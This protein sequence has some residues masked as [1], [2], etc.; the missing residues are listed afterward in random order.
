[1]RLDS[2]PLRGLAVP[3]GDVVPPV[4]E[5]YAGG[6]RLQDGDWVDKNLTLTGVVRDESGLNLLDPASN[7]RQGFGLYLN[8]NKDDVLDL[9]SYFNYDQDQYQV[10]RFIVNLALPEV[11]DT[12]TVYV[13]DN[14]YNRA[15]ARIALRVATDERLSVEDFLIYPNPVRAGAYFTFELSVGAQVELGVYTV[16]GRLIRRLVNVAGQTGFNKVWWDGLDS[17]GD[18]PANG[19]Y[20]VKLKAERDQSGAAESVSRIERFIIAH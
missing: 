15:E 11:I 8:Q 20:L 1:M 3:S 12:I 4:L 6:R 10:G 9:R 7:E 16:A 2:V 17:Q 14:N 18:R 19:V 5:F 13:S